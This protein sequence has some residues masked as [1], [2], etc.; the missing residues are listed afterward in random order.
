[1]TLVY[2]GFAA[3]IFHGCG[4]E[5]DPLECPPQ[6]T[7]E[8]GED[9]T[10]LVGQWMATMAI[11]DVELDLTNDEIDNPSVDIFSQY[12]ECAQDA[13]F[14]FNVNRIYSYD[15]GTMTSGC[16][17]STT[18]GTWKLSSNALFLIVSCGSVTYNLSFN[19]ELSQFEYTNE[20]DVQEVN[21]IITPARV[22]FTFN[23][24]EP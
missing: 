4:I 6:F 23:K 8:L 21:G 13:I 20:I 1:M 17:E 18:Q 12:S 2:V 11:S 3:L 7:G 19:D 5:S 15:I 24:V 9:E 10:K 14:N 22:T 16:T